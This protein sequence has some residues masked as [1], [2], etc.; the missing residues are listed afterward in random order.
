MA[1]FGIEKL[2]GLWEWILGVL[3]V[4]TIAAMKVQADKE[5]AVGEVYEDQADVHLAD[6][7]NE[8][9]QAKESNQQAVDIAK[10]DTVPNYEKLPPGFKR[11]GIS[12][13]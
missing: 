4:S 12:S 7:V 6:S 11:T 5:K 13:E 2:A 8:V 10:D 1:F 3:G 9:N